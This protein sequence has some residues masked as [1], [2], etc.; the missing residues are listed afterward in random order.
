MAF[1]KYATT[2]FIFSSVF[3]NG[4]K[5]EKQKKEGKG[6]RIAHPIK[7]KFIDLIARQS[8]YD[9]N[10]F[11]D[12]STADHDINNLKIRINKNGDLICNSDN[13]QAIEIIITNETILKQTKDAIYSELSFIPKTGSNSSSLTKIPIKR[14]KNGSSSFFS[15]VNAKDNFPMNSEA[16]LVCSKENE[17]VLLV[18]KY[19]EKVEF[20]SGP[21][22]VRVSVSIYKDPLRP[23]GRAFRITIVDGVS[24]LSNKQN[25]FVWFMPLKSF[26]EVYN[27]HMAARDSKNEIYCNLERPANNKTIKL[28]CPSWDTH[29]N[30]Y[31]FN[32]VLVSMKFGTI[33]MRSVLL[34]RIKNMQND[35]MELKVH[36]L[37]NKPQNDELY[38][39]VHKNPKYSA[40]ADNNDA[41][42]NA[43]LS[44]LNSVESLH[45]DI[46][47]NANEAN[48]LNK[49][50]NVL[51]WSIIGIPNAIY[52]TKETIK[53]VN[54]LKEVNREFESARPIY[55]WTLTQT[56]NNHQPDMALEK[57][58]KIYFQG[59]NSLNN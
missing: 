7:E 55:E 24:V 8:G 10:G 45:H 43:I 44:K 52:V 33:L 57:K 46:N 14:P 9:T 16:Y 20:I 5:A 22:L 4:L 37:L 25:S 31:N 32:K 51:I 15:N 41:E 19:L 42:K 12:L 38:P 1:I 30:L 6:F 54:R 21:W 18:P 47:I 11:V 28:D 29:Y 39:D 17:N 56:E 40:I 34:P 36:H 49:A 35:G 13:N 3:L 23:F 59:S 50:L 26:S 2:L 48:I 58:K 53:L 27:F